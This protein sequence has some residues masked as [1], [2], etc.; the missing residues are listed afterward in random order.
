MPF[1][2]LTRV[3]LVATPLV[4]AVLLL[5]GCESTPKQP[6]APPV[7]QLL[8]PP[9]LQEAPAPYRA[10]LHT[11]IAAGF[12]ERGQFDVALQELADAVKLDPKNARIYNI[13]GLVYAM[14]GQDSDAQRNF[15]QALELGPNDSE[16]RQNWGWYLC[17]HGR[18]KESLVEFDTALRNP[19]YRTPDIAAV[20]AGRC[21]EEVGERRRAEDYFKRALQA[22]PANLTAAYSLSLLA[23]R[24]ARLD[25]ARLLMKRVMQQTA[26]P[27]EALYLGMCIERKLGDR[28]SETS[29]ASQLRN[30]FP[31]SA[32]AKAI[33]PGTCE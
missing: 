9:P 30:R 12:Y 29:Y 26:P 2:R 7:P 17:T 18:A 14:L 20:N 8:P 27:P 19:L 28:A 3:T 13:Y 31:D 21:A 10:Q 23:Y 32:E 4:A 6:P 22:N 1:P 5:A 11:D 33:P 15:Q 24:E 25:E 16:I